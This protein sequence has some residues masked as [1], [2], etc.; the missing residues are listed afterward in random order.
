MVG[1]RAWLLLAAADLSAFTTTSGVAYLLRARTRPGTAL[2]WLGFIEGTALASRVQD[3]VLLQHHRIEVLVTRASGDPAIEPTL[4]AARE[5]DLPVIVARRPAPEI[6]AEVAS[7]DAALGW[8]R[9]LLET[10]DQRS[11]TV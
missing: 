8:I 1:S 9:L 7:I 10:G 6:G 4:A 2:N 11:A 5:L 3:R